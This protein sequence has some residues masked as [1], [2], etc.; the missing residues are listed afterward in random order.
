MSLYMYIYVF[1]S[2][3]L[4][5]YSVYWNRYFPMN[6]HVRLLLV[7]R[8]DWSHRSVRRRRRLIG[9]DFQTGKGKSHFHAP[10]GAQLLKTKLSFFFLLLLFHQSLQE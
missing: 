9:H 3:F 2:V 4:S 7:S 10:I 1:L 5:L 8:I 6:P